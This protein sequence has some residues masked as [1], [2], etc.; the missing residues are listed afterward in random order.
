[1]EPLGKRTVSSG[2]SE[3]FCT[4]ERVLPATVKQSATLRRRIKIKEMKRKRAA[5]ARD[6]QTIT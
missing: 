3:Y 2:T 6:L 1:M 4:T 5:K